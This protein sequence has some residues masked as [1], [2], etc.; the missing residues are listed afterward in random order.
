LFEQY[1]DKINFNNRQISGRIHN[2]IGKIQQLK[3]LSIDETAEFEKRIPSFINIKS[4]R[5]EDLY[6]LTD[7]IDKYRTDKQRIKQTP[8]NPS[9]SRSHLYLVF[10]IEFQSGK[11]GFVT[12]VDTAGRESPLD[13]FNTFIDTTNT[14]LPS[15]M[16]P[17]PVGGV[18]NITKNL[19]P[20]FKEMYTPEQVFNILNEGF[21]INETINH[22]VFYFN[23]KNGKTIETPKQKVDKRYNVVYKI[24]NYFV[25][26]QEES[27]SIDGN[28][29]SLMI[30][31]LKFLDNLSAKQKDQDWKP[32]KFIT[33]CC[34]RQE[35]RYCDQTM[36]TIQFAQNV[37]SS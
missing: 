27:N 5:V 11:R 36:E 15:V 8:N 23:L 34:V 21:Y 13:I 35:S 25:Q 16:A 22:L 6:S 28:N 2:L 10:E 24:Q 18:S 31:I 9:S 37:K 14:S 12:I 32:T 1:Y 17:P 33:I 7:T 30:P 29:N 19:K 4:L 3:D 26:P 20:E